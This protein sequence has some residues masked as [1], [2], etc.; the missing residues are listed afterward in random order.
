MITCAEFHPTHCNTLAY[1]SSK[2]TI[3]LIDLR[4]SA[5]CDNHAKL[6]VIPPLTSSV[7][8]LLIRRQCLDFVISNG[9][10]HLSLPIGHGIIWFN[11]GIL[12]RFEEHE[13][14]G[15]RSFF[16]EIIASV[17]DIKF[18]R[19]GRHILSRDYMSLK[20]CNIPICPNSTT[21]TLYDLCTR[22]LKTSILLPEKHMSKCSSSFSIQILRHCV[23]LSMLYK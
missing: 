4:Q 10:K 14:P 22:W 20:V 18:A 7:T 2:G 13:A 15:S 6:L 9:Y 3:R 5:L 17:S 23:H 12:F 21:F 16:T 19:D 8:L 11:W 1:S